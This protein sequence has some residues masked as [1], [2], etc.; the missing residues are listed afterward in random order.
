MK[1]MRFGVRPFLVTVVTA[2]SGATGVAQQPPG[3]PTTAA[4]EVTPC[5]QAQMVVDQLLAHLV[6][7][8]MATQ[9]G[10]QSPHEPS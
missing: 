9:T 4:A 3:P 8:F 6:P 1:A 5:V 7:Y 10:R 2:L